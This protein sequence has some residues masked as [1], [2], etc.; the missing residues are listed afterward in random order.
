MAKKEVTTT[1][2]AKN[3]GL[4]TAADL[5]TAG[6]D[7]VVDENSRKRADESQKRGP[8]ENRN[9]IDS[10]SPHRRD[11]A[12]G[13]QAREHKNRTDQKRQRHRPLQRLR[14]A[15]GA[16]LPDER[17]GNAVEDVADDLHQKPDGEHETEHQK[18]EQGTREKR[19][20]NVSFYYLHLIF[21][22]K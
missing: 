18:R 17:H 2:H 10:A 19:T 8:F 13:R 20:E 21:S 14:Q 1:M 4:E 11:L 16:E 12:V 6:N 15:H 7:L 22:R 3:L 9:E 5:V